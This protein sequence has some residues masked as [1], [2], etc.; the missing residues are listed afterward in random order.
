MDELLDMFEATAVARCSRKR[1]TKGDKMWALRSAVEGIIGEDKW[2]IRNGELI[3]KMLMWISQYL[4]HGNVAA[5]ANLSK[6]KIMTHT[7]QPIYS[8]KEVE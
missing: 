2:L 6:L 3:R 1:V 8:I 5:M 4:N 7:K